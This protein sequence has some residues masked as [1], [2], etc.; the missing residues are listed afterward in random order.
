MPALTRSPQRRHAL[1]VTARTAAALVAGYA[2]AYAFTA[3]MAVVLPF[4]R[5]ERVL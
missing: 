3:S 2:A 1:D 5:A 4:A